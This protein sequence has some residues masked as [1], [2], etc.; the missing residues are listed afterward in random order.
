MNGI[1]NFIIT[2]VAIGIVS[3]FVTF[4]IIL[5]LHKKE[6]WDEIYKRYKFKDK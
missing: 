6:L 3:L 2:I 4:F 5:G 1:T